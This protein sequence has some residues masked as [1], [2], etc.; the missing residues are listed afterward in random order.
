[1]CENS[2]CIFVCVTFSSVDK[3]LIL[4]IKK[5]KEE[6]CLKFPD[7]FKTDYSYPNRICMYQG[8]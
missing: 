2:I 6:S 7:N 3:R 5:S 4:K 1:M 8:F